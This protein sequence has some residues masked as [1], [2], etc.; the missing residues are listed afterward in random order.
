MKKKLLLTLALSLTVTLAACGM[1]PEE[2]DTVL[3]NIETTYQ[4]GAYD[5]AKTAVEELDKSYDKMSEEQKSKYDNLSSSVEYAVTSISAINEGLEKAQSY[6]DQKMYY[7]ASAELGNLTS[8]YTLPPA[9]QAKYDEKKSAVDAAIAQ[10]KITETLNNVEA[11]LNGGDYNAASD[12]LSA[13]DTSSLTEEQSQK[14]QSLQSGIAT[15]KAEAE[16][17][18]KAK[19]AV[20]DVDVLSQRLGTR[21]VYLYEEGGPLYGKYEQCEKVNTDS[22]YGVKYGDLT[23]LGSRALDGD[24]VQFSTTNPKTFRK[25]GVSLDKSYNE[26]VTILGEPELGGPEQGIYW[27]TFVCDGYSLSF[28]FNDPAEAPYEVIVHY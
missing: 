17:A 3:T 12:A 6:Y 19:A 21:Q 25:N 9:E 15:K 18:A 11:T 7:E 8:A 10:W 22:E 13:I 16:A 27:Y 28:K 5:E 23:V 2:I 26:L 20:Y 1:T 24:I 14:Y 4:S